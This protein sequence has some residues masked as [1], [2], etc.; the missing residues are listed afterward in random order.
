MPARPAGH[1]RAPPAAPAAQADCRVPRSATADAH[2]EL[3][4]AMS[5]REGPLP[6]PDPMAP[7]ISSGNPD[8]T[9]R[10]FS[11]S[12]AANTITTRSA[13]SRRAANASALAEGRS[14]HWTSSTRQRT[15]DASAV[16]ASNDSTPAE[17]PEPVA[18]G[19][20]R[21]AERRRQ[22]VSLR[23]GQLGQPV[24]DR[25]QQGVQASEGKVVLDFDTGCPQDRH[26]LPAV[27][28][29]A[30]QRR[31]AHPSLTSHDERSAASSARSLEQL[32]EF[33]AFP[34]AS[35][36]PC[37][38]HESPAAGRSAQA[39]RR[40]AA[41]FGVIRHREQPVPA[42]KASATS[43]SAAPPIRRPD[44]SPDTRHD[45]VTGRRVTSQCRCTST[46]LRCASRGRRWRCQR[47]H[48]SSCQATRSRR[49]R[50]PPSHCVVVSR[51]VVV[52]SVVPAPLACVA[53]RLRVRVRSAPCA[54]GGGA[55]VFVRPQ[56]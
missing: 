30:E 41:G 14:S 15:G 34:L 10:R 24:D 35:E 19:A 45:R 53:S 7:S 11:P 21:Q 55:E 4:A 3:R 16:A 31:L 8:S 44:R 39:R 38:L 46:P 49:G 18:A 42:P 5:G 9:N 26:T 37:G 54:C 17:I 23:L 51:G 6:T 33:R 50:A 47:T 12:R 22:G 40:V 28:H 2:A 52:S 13:T 25:P 1:Q 36:Q 32:I 29:V 27:G 43:R 48:T 56:F 20:R